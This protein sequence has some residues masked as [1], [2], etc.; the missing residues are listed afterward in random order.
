MIELL[1]L[2]LL[3]CFLGMAKVQGPLFSIDAS[4]KIADAMVHFPWKGLHVVREWLKPT[5]PQS[6]NQ[7]NRRVMLGGLGRSVKYVQTTSDYATWARGVAVAPDTWVSAYVKYIQATYFPTVAAFDAHHDEFNTHAHK[8]A[9]DTRADA[10]GL[11]VFDLTYKDMTYGFA[12]GH[13]LYCLAKHGCDQYLLNNAKFN[14][15]PYI[16]ALADWD[17]TEIVAMI[18]DFAAA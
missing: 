14:A 7:G 1:F 10:L 16:T 4:G 3:F 11:T 5:N 8:G 13:Q 6:A 2:Y 12:Q 18:A 15:E 9:W 17:D